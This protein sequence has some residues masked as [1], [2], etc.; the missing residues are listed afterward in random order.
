MSLIFYEPF[1]SNLDFFTSVTNGG[2]DYAWTASGYG[3][4]PGISVT[5]NDTGGIY[6][7]KTLSTLV[8]QTQVRFAGYID[9]NTISI[10]TSG[11]TALLIWRNS[12]T[13]TQRAKVS[14]YNSSGTISLV[15]DFRDDGGTVSQ[16]IVSL[17]GVTDFRWELLITKAANSSSNDAT[18]KLYWDSTG[19]GLVLKDTRTCGVFESFLSQ[20]EVILGP[21]SVSGTHSGT[22]LL[23]PFGYR[24]DGTEIGAYSWASAPVVAAGAN[25]TGTFGT[26][27]VVTTVSFTDADSDADE[28]NIT[29]ESG[30]TITV[31]ANGSAVVTGNTSAAVNVTGTQ[32]E[33]LNT[34]ASITLN[35][36]QD[37]W[38]DETNP[39]PIAYFEYTDT[40]TVEVIDS[41]DLSHSDSFDIVWSNATGNGT[42][43]LELTDTVMNDMNAQIAAAYYVPETDFEGT[44]YLY[45]KLVDGNAAVSEAII[46][47]VVAAEV[48]TPTVPSNFAIQNA[49]IPTTR[50]ERR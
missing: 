35:R 1:T 44:T 14:L 31:T 23:G 3:G 46:S 42:L 24:D 18:S 16:G 29:C 4:H 2:G 45:V 9:L 19:S 28:A 41:T 22:Y 17:A 8:S 25:Q 10:P 26:P 32:T 39:P 13:G 33:V 6:G 11:L 12:G 36:A 5:I 43:V 15:H 27:K 50:R 40:V 49:A 34:L 7:T 20:N 21:F 37:G 38:T 30:G 47:L 48:P